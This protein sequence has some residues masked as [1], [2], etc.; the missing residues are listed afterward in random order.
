MELNLMDKYNKKSKFNHLDFVSGKHD[1]E[2][3]GSKII[4]ALKDQ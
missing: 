1:Y 4:A 2:F 3:Y